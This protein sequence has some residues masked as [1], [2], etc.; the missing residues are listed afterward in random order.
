MMCIGSSFSA[1]PWFFMSPWDNIVEMLCKRAALTLLHAFHPPPVFK[2]V[3]GCSI[4]IYLVFS[5]N[6]FFM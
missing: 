3:G 1:F 4:I 6:G 2:P 5:G